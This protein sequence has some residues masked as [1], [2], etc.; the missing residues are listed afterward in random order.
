MWS[1]PLTWRF[2]QPFQ[3]LLQRRAAQMRLHVIKTLPPQL[4]A[5]VR[6]R[7]RFAAP[8]DL[9]CSFDDCHG[10][11]ITRPIYQEDRFG[12]HRL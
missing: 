6:Y 2:D 9:E 3:L 12:I 7:A 10:K 4:S 5:D 11:A 8:R 1:H